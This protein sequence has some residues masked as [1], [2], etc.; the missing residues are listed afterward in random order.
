MFSGISTYGWMEASPNY[1]RCNIAGLDLM[2]TQFPKMGILSI[3]IGSRNTSGAGL[4]LIKDAVAW[5]KRNNVRAI[6]SKY[7]VFPQTEADLHTFWAIFAREFLGDKTIVCFDVFN[8]PWDSRTGWYGN[9]ELVRVY[10]RVI[11]TIRA[12]DPDRVVGVQSYLKHEETMSWVRTNPVNRPN[13][14]YVVHLYSNS[15]I[16]GAWWTWQNSHPWSTYYLTEQYEEAR[17]VLYNGMY[18]RFGFLSAELNLP[19][20][21]TEVAFMPTEEGLKY[22][23]DVLEIL[24]EWQINWCYHS[25]YSPG[26]G[27]GR[28]M[29]LIDYNTKELRAMAAIVKANFVAL[30]PPIPDGNGNGDTRFLLLFLIFLFVFGIVLM[31]SSKKLRSPYKK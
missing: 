9:A 23:N 3:P 17:Q 4:Q 10:E 15:W 28:P 24:T 19:V 11:D 30:P 16:S 8:E 18:A 25:W 12:I 5:C 29:T 27:S 22:G 7:N 31:S 21:I 13:V 2:K 26:T 6:L 1:F 14:I 20:L